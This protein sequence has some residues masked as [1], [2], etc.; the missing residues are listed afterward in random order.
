MKCLK[1]LSG[2]ASLEAALILPTFLL[3]MG[4]LIEPLCYFYTK[5]IMQAA[6][7]DA[8]RLV[9][10]GVN[11]TDEQIEAY[12]KRRLKAV[13]E[14]SI[15]HTGG[16]ADW[17][18]DISGPDDEGIVIVEITGHLRLLPIGQLAMGVFKQTDDAGIVLRSYAEGLYRPEWLKGG[19]D[20]WQEIW[21]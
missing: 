20:D 8:A 3:V 2:Q 9:C 16:E 12:I 19:Y 4:M 11:L 7:A 15:F 21:E 5:S 13:P 17:T 6:A 1:S 10:T 14:I 18:F